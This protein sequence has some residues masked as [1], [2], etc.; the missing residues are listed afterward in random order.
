MT[1]EVRE[2]DEDYLRSD[3][4][5]MNLNEIVVDHLSE[6]EV[7]HEVDDD[8]ND[9]YNDDDDDDDQNENQYH[10]SSGSNDNAVPVG[11]TIAYKRYVSADAA[12]ETMLPSS[13]KRS[14]IS[15]ATGTWNMGKRTKPAPQHT[16]SRRIGNSK[17]NAK[18]Y[19]D[20]KKAKWSAHKSLQVLLDSSLI[21][22][23]CIIIPPILAYFYHNIASIQEVTWDTIKSLAFNDGADIITTTPNDDQLSYSYFSVLG[24]VFD[25][26]NEYQSYRYVKSTVYDPGIHYICT[27]T[28][29]YDTV[30]ASSYSYYTSYLWTT[31]L[32]QTGLCPP[33][34]S[35]CRQRP[36]RS[37]IS[38]DMSIYM[39]VFYITICSFLLAIAR[40]MIV[41][42][43]IFKNGGTSGEIYD[44][45]V[46]DDKNIFAVSN[47]DALTVFV[48]CKS[49]H[50]LSSDYDI[51]SS[52]PDHSIHQRRVKQM[53]PDAVS[54]CMVT[55]LNE[56]SQDD[57]HVPSDC[58]SINQNVHEDSANSSNIEMFGI[59]IDVSDRD[60]NSLNRSFDD[61]DSATI[62]MN[63]LAVGVSAATKTFH[64]KQLS[65]DI[66]TQHNQSDD[67]ET[68]ADNV[69]SNAVL[70]ALSSE[71]LHRDNTTSRH[72]CESDHEIE[73]KKQ[74][75]H[76]KQRE[77]RKLMYA[78]P[79]YATAIFR[80]L[81]CT[82]TAGIALLYFRHADFWP[83][84]VFGTGRGTKQCWDLS[85]GIT[86]GGM[87]S[88]FDQHNE[89]LKRYFL[90]QASYH[91]HSTTFHCLL[92]MAFLFYP[93]VTS[94]TASMYSND[95]IDLTSSSPSKRLRVIKRGSHAYVRSFIQHLLSLVL[96]AVAYI[97]SSLRRLGAIGLFAFDVSSWSLHLL[98][99]CINAPDDS[100]LWYFLPPK[101]Q[102]E[103]GTFN[104]GLYL[105]LVIPSFVIA[106]F[107]IWP[108]LW[109]SVAYESKSWLQQ[110]EMTLWPGS[111]LLL[112][113]IMHALMLIL[114]CISLL[115]LR[116]LLFH[117]LFSK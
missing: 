35:L 48:R 95:D 109:Y 103:R 113:I 100:Y 47:V 50:L 56:I 7:A 2:I 110:L 99:I 101:F 32:E 91:I 4:D 79:R 57:R 98:Q 13:T 6:N 42:Y 10:T 40:M 111:A 104:R 96:I 14:R 16:T 45:D 64:N 70:N 89:V 90:W 63:P 84:F 51:V 115:Y 12:E 87:D 29:K 36:R 97:F 26:L 88:D 71:T 60:S 49:N 62:R 94:T 28:K 20:K 75:S 58:V 54:Q 65:Q 11:I 8:Y 9:E 5:G 117:R 24:P 19:R 55:N 86:V 21:Y 80:L 22:L 39:D 74:C 66:K 76:R 18:E 82:I 46:S 83:W 52:T 33:E 41:H 61:N 30:S 105:Y 116:R 34:Y 77:Y 1:T 72:L 59:N 44:T 25:Y 17:R 53:S 43:T 106:R 107:M 31:V 23:L 73:E 108:A 102:K 68:I 78:A 69:D 85:G 67:S 114:H 112:R 92:S 37:V 3:I 38:D 81:Y 27:P 15:H 93:F